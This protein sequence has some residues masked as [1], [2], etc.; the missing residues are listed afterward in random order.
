MRLLSP[1]RARPGRE[2]STCA[3]GAK[4]FRAC[5]VG[6]SSDVARGG[7][8]QE[9][10]ERDFLK[11]LPRARL[12][13]YNSALDACARRYARRG[14]IDATIGPRCLRCRS[15]RAVFGR[16]GRALYGP[17]QFKAVTSAILGAARADRLGRRFGVCVA[18]L[19]KTR[20][21][22]R[23]GG[24]NTWQLR[25]V[26]E[27]ASAEPA[28]SPTLK[29]VVE[30]AAARK[31]LEVACMGERDPERLRKAARSE[32]TFSTP[33]ENACG[34]DRA[35]P[36]LFK[37]RSTCPSRV[38][39][40]ESTGCAQARQSEPPCFLPSPPAFQVARLLPSSRL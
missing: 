39:H 25:V 20:Y 37:E 21:P 9:R 2:R 29:S 40:P 36:D 7:A 14:G 30:V 8:I 22:P 23:S 28:A 27:W 18:A 15:C 12:R 26:Q 16:V 4:V 13:A 35:G 31:L 11:H 19:P 1:D 5:L 17:K 33:V 34:H 6:A 24:T 38:K 10:C 3:A 32:G